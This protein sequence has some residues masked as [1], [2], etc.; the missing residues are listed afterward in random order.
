[1][2]A[3]YL[4]TAANSKELEKSNKSYN[5][6]LQTLQKDIISTEETLQG[7]KERKEEQMYE[8]LKPRLEKLQHEASFYAAKRAGKVLFKDVNYRKESQTAFKKAKGQKKKED[9][10]QYKAELLALYTDR[11]YNLGAKAGAKHTLDDPDNPAAKR[12]KEDD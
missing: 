7:Y 8:K 10:E 1:M 11:V 12:A 4:A 5:N 3:D 9:E 6:K 2:Y